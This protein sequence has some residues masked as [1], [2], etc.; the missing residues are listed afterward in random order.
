MHIYRMVKIVSISDDVYKKLVALKG[1]KSFSKFIEELLEK[2]NKDYIILK[3]L[4][5]KIKLSK[6]EANELLKE[7]EKK[8]WEKR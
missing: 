7:I 3:R 6:K 4:S 1:N 8:R 2:E 5:E